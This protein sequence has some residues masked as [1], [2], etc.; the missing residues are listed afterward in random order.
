MTGFTPSN[1]DIDDAI[2]AFASEHPAPTEA[3][4]FAR[5]R[6]AETP[7]WYWDFDAVVHMSRGNVAF[8]RASWRYAMRLSFGFWPVRR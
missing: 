4:I 5:K 8:A 1:S 7:P 2:V 6:H 3:G